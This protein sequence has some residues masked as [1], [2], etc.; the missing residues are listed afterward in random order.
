ME[1]NTILNYID[2]TDLLI[3][4]NPIRPLFNK[5][6]LKAT[7]N[8][9]NQDFFWY[10]NAGASG[11]Q[12]YPAGL[13]KYFDLYSFPG[14]LH[15]LKEWVWIW[16]CILLSPFTFFIPLNIWIAMF[17]GSSFEGVWKLFFT[18]R[19]TWLFNITD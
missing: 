14:Y 17:D 1:P 19:L 15:Y 11:S 2:R 4:S 8:G 18:K 12:L 6:F 5:N 16:F 10:N 9:D 13:S 3:E 7:I